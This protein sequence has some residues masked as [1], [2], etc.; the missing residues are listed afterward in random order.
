MDSQYHNLRAHTAEVGATASDTAETGNTVQRLAYRRDLQDDEVSSISDERNEEEAESNRL[1]E[2]AYVSDE[3]TPQMSVMPTSHLESNSPGQYEHH[4][5]QQYRGGIMRLKNYAHDWWLFELGALAI[6]YMAMIAL[7]IILKLYENEPVPRWPGHINLNALISVTST[8]MKAAIAVPITASISQMKWVWF[9][10][11]N[12]I[13]G[14]QVFDEAS[15]GPLGALKLLFSKYVLSLASLGALIILLALGMDPFFQQV[16][17]YP[18]E[19]RVETHVSD[20]SVAHLPK[21]S[22][23]NSVRATEKTGDPAAEYA[24]QQ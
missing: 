5:A 16:V 22:S 17:S 9:K 11:R 13:R 2:R 20:S 8:I 23:Y 15:R 21:G 4:S 6:S 7:V 19:L 10:E 14:M 24:M 1:P 12:P 18:L 3:K